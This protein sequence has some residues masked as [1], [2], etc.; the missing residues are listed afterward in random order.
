MCSS[1]AASAWDHTLD[2]EVLPHLQNIQKVSPSLTMR[3]RLCDRHGLLSC[4][5]GWGAFGSTSHL[6]QI[7]PCRSTNVREQFWHQ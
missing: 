5:L 7:P 4:G 2:V 6:R 3:L 1:K